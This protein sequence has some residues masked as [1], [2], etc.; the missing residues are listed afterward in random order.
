MSTDRKRVDEISRFLSYVL[1]HKPQAIDLR[2]DNEG[3]ADIDCLIA[4]AARHGTALDL[5]TIREVVTT[6]DK[7]RF[8]ISDDSQRICAV[9]GHSTPTVQRGYPEKQPPDVLYHGTA[10]RFLESIRKHGLNAGSRHHVHLS[11]DI[12][13]ANAVGKR[14][15]VPV[16]L[17]IQARRMHEQGFKFLLAE[18]N[19][20]LIKA[21]P[22]E[23]LSVHGELMP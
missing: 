23:F 6:S 18:N 9:Q 2:L 20:W 16:I 5:A 17:E 14:Y 10:T 12:S 3:W 22:A 7:K 19:V 21:V 4:G 13:T 8:V 15:G 1:R 11:Q